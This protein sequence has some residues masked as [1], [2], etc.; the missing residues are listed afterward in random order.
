MATKK[1]VKENMA[2]EIQEEQLKDIREEPQE[3]EVPED[4]WKQTVRM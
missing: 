3:A 2:D 1:T 4:P